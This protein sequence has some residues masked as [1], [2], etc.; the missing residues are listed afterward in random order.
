[1]EASELRRFGDRCDRTCEV[2]MRELRWGSGETGG[3]TKGN[4]SGLLGIMRACGA[5]HPNL[6]FSD[7]TQVAWR[8]LQQEYIHHRNQQ[9]L[10]II[11]LESFIPESCLP[12][13]P[14]GERRI[15]NSVWGT[16][17]T[18]MLTVVI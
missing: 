9:M 4:G 7:V 6:T 16:L 15:N 11:Y 12:S 18:E 17:D 2:G 3:T 5:R 13:T 1:M 8:E 10:Q 14:M